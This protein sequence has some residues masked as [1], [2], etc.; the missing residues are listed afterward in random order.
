MNISIIYNLQVN[1]RDVSENFIYS[2]D[3]DK[4]GYLVN[5]FLIS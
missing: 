3:L 1:L 4:S 2:I 5:S